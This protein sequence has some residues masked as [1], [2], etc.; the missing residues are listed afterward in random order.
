MTSEWA[1][2][3]VGVL[4][5]EPQWNTLIIRT[6]KGKKF[7][8]KACQEGYLLVEKMPDENLDHLRFAAGNK[9]KRAF[10]QAREEGVLN[11]TEDGKRSALRVPTEVVEKIIG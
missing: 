8:E 10:T 11:S 7:I 9:K 4:E 1:D 5:E 6:D 3:S 2:V